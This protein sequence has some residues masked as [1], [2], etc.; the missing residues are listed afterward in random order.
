VAPEIYNERELRRPKV[1]EGCGNDGHG[2]GLKHG[3]SGGVGVLGRALGVKAGAMSGDAQ[4]AGRARR[5]DLQVRLDP[6]PAAKRIGLLCL[7][8]DHVSEADFAAALLPLGVHLHTARVAYANPTNR[9]NL[10]KMLPQLSEA[11]ALILPGESLDA[12]CY[13]CTAATVVMGDAAVAEAMH[14]AKPGVPLV[15][16]VSAA[17]AGFQALGAH[18]ISV[19]T[20]YTA[21]VT[22]ELLDYFRAHGLEIVDA[23]CLGLDDDREIARVDRGTI[24]AAARQVAAERADALFI[25]CTALRAAGLAQDIEDAIG[26]PVVTSNQAGIWYALRAAGIADGLPGYGRLLGLQVAPRVA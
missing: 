26:R 4:E 2:E 20:P 9:A 1:V 16:P 11:A 5:L 10:L 14:Q 21:A 13:S 24:V 18:R 6:R 19:L 23:A 7:A 15:T 3:H 12:I 17:R 22:A 8:T 25:S